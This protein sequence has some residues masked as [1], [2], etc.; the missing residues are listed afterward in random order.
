MWREGGDPNQIVKQRGLE[1]VSD[2]GAIEKA[3]DAVIAANADKAADVKQKPKLIGWFA[4]QV[5]KAT[6]G[7]ANP[8]GIHS[9]IWQQHSHAG[10]LH[11]ICESSP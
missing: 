7:K 9:V 1:Q 5:M 11:P 6:G 3:I 4:G 10:R 2:E 8:A